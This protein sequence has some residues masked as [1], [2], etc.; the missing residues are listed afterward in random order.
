M[1]KLPIIKQVRKFLQLFIALS[2]KSTAMAVKWITSGETGYQ[3][4]DNTARKVSYYFGEGSTFGYF[5][6][7]VKYI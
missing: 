3:P 7:L 6:K 2:I 4:L 1:R 5:E